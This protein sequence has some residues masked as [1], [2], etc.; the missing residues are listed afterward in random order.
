[1]N[2]KQRR[3]AKS[4]GRADSGPPAWAGPAGASGPIAELLAVA[5]AHHRAG[6][7]VEAEALYRQIRAID[8]GHVH[9]LYLLA[10]LMGQT[11]RTDPAIDAM[12]QVLSRKPDF[13][14]AHNDLG[15]LLLA[16]GKTTEAMAC[17]ERALACKPDYAEAS[18]NQGIALARMNR[19][20]DAVK[21]YE[22]ALA[23]K[24]GYHEAHHNLGNIFNK[25]GRLADASRRYRQA[26][27][28][29]ADYAEAHN[30][31]GVVLLRQDEPGAALA[32]FERA[33][34]IKPDNAEARNNLGSALRNLNRPSEAVE[35][36]DRAL[37]L[38][39]DYLEALNNRGNALQAL[40]RVA[41]AM[42]SFDKALAINPDYDEAH[43]N[44][45]CL[46]LLS[47]DFEP[48]WEEYEW[49]WK[50]RAAAPWRR[51]FAQPLWL[52]GEPL[53]ER[54][55]LLHDEQ[56]FGDAIQFVRYLPLVATMAAKVILEVQ[57]PLKA[58]LSG[59]AGASLIV[60]R[61]EDLPAF[62]FRCPLLSLP[63]AFKTRPDTIPAAVPYL[64]ASED[65]IIKWKQ[66]LPPSGK[67]RIGIAWAGNPAFIG[68]RTRSIG[69][70]RLSP[71]LSVAGVEFYSIQRDLR[72]G[73][74]TFCAAIPTSCNWA[75]PWRISTTPRPSYHCS[76]WS[77]RRTH[78]SCI[79]PAP[80]AS[81]CG[82]SCNMPRI[83]AGS[84]TATT[85]LGIRPR[86]CF[87]SR[88]STIGRASWRA[89]CRSC[90]PWAER[91]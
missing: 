80:W 19:L 55:I 31:L 22:R 35:C 82:F 79:W 23:L 30:G 13:A 73:I 33:L 24:P 62:D 27:A 44:R 68:D 38:K 58:L 54:T 32:C 53:A 63:L 37:A 60:G 86:G 87:G 18:Y 64:S 26:L 57:P 9:N 74:V 75:T 36:Y 12:G 7:L 40:N 70:P 78:R 34:A 10:V 46:R 15:A 69:L 50:T 11:G 66:R 61:G 3:V 76:I 67:R 51:D 52:G 65:R 81:R 84:W 88:Q 42:A 56:G 6:R 1:M 28:L 45:S 39:P 20:D 89:S 91:R 72:D 77:S 43:W 5:L 29:K 4:Q 25:Q 8:P 2:R 21:R 90:C 47:G 16:Q 14:E 59:I 71:L 49:R 83:G 48:G 85:A 41:E 17:F